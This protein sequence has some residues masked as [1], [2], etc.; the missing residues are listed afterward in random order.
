MRILRPSRMVRRSP[1]G[2]HQCVYCEALF[3]LDATDVSLQV[4][5]PNGD[6][7]LRCPSCGEL[8]K[9]NGLD[10]KEPP[11]EGAAMPLNPEPSVQDYIG[12]YLAGQ[13]SLGKL[14]ELVPEHWDLVEGFASIIFDMEPPPCS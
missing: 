10:E 5:T 4:P 6:I 11:C 7:W 2:R 13:I 3:E 8:L 12:Q 14:L 9:L 1:V